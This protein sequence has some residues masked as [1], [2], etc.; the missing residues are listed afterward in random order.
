MPVIENYYCYNAGAD[1]VKVTKIRIGAETVTMMDRIS[2]H[3]NQFIEELTKDNS[4]NS[5]A[6]EVPSDKTWPIRKE[7]ISSVVR[8]LLN[9]FEAWLRENEPELLSIFKQAKEKGASEEELRDSFNF[10]S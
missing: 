1:L 8:R 6:P 4:S 10:N 5:S 7:Y 3:E 2:F 9:N